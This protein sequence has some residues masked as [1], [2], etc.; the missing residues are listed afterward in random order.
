MPWG[1][2]WANM[3]SDE[4]LRFLAGVVP[5]LYRQYRPPHPRPRKSIR[6]GKLGVGRPR[7]LSPFQQREL[8]AREQAFQAM[9]AARGLRPSQ[10]AFVRTECVKP[11]E[12]HARRQELYRAKRELNKFA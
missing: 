6:R 7:K 1:H 9:R 8:V 5:D 10:S 12:F 4:V 3:T 2:A 11:H